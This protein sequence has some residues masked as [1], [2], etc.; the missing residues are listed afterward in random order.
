MG[1]Q[2]QASKERNLN[3]FKSR[4]EEEVRKSFLN[5]KNIVHDHRQQYDNRYIE[6]PTYHD[7]SFRK[8]RLTS[9]NV[10]P[11]KESAVKNWHRPTSD[12][13]S[14]NISDTSDDHIGD[15]KR[16]INQIDFQ[17]FY[18]P[19]HKRKNQVPKTVI[20][21]SSSKKEIVEFEVD[22]HDF[23]NS[24]ENAGNRESNVV[25]GFQHSAESVTQN[26]N[27]GTIN[28]EEES[29]QSTINFDPRINIAE[30]VYLQP[31]TLQ[32]TQNLKNYK[33]HYDDTNDLEWREE[34]FPPNLT[35]T[36]EIEEIIQYEEEESEPSEPSKQSLRVS[37]PTKH[38]NDLM[39]RI[40]DSEKPNAENFR[41]FKLAQVK[42]EVSH[43]LSSLERDRN[44]RSDED[45]MI[46]LTTI[47]NPLYKHP[48]I[49]KENKHM[50]HYDKIMHLSNSKHD[51]DPIFNMHDSEVFKFLI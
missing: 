30:N 2:S 11:D 17:H 48:I 51:Y 49:E 13:G 43:S 38:Q 26:I 12:S 41:H 29:K 40:L 6:K 23:S 31:K 36:G 21:E 46:N 35:E 45:T 27:Y 47:E 14:E 8:D 7:W 32:E 9:H 3:M 22:M 10:T 50:N 4:V 39:N 15:N 19:A 42:N 28:E 24:K 44:S 34:I 20:I 1:H 37:S 18:S 25:D 16:K 5:A 33:D